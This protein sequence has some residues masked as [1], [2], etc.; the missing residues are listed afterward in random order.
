MY[1][2]DTPDDSLA[3]LGPGSPPL[4]AVHEGPALR[5]AV[6]FTS[7]GPEAAVALAG[8]QIADPARSYFRDGMELW[9]HNLTHALIYRRNEVLNQARTREV[10]VSRKDG[11]VD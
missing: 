3:R 5:L 8:G 4:V 1:T 2:G 11:S 9:R 10:A 7:N 6:R